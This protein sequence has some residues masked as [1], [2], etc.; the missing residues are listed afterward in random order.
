MKKAIICY[1]SN[2]MSN[3][4]ASSTISKLEII[5]I[6]GLTVERKNIDKINFIKHLRKLKEINELP[7]A[8]Y[9]YKYNGRSNQRNNLLIEKIEK[10]FPEVNIEIYTIDLIYTPERVA[11]NKL[12]T[13]VY[14]LE[15]R[16]R[17]DFLNDYVK[18]NVY[19]LKISELHKKI[20]NEDNN[21]CLIEE[22][23][24]NPFD[25]FHPKGQAAYCYPTKNEAIN[26]L[27]KCLKVYED[28]SASKVEKAKENLMIAE[29]EL[30]K[31]KNNI[32]RVINEA[33]E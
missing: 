1:H 22:V 7:I 4:I 21:D 29:S 33:K 16:M 11:G 23:K 15:S 3:S 20:Q 26:M 28:S 6:K 9:I 14:L 31:V 27:E 17:S 24:V 10:E 18:L 30:S 13:R 5:P 2:E 12:K 8:V 25:M 19:K 32:V